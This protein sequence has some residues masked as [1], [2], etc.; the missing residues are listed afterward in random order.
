MSSILDDLENISKQ[1]REE[2]QI[3]NDR[4]K[5]SNKEEVTNKKKEEDKLIDKLLYEIYTLIEYYTKHN[6]CD[7]TEN[8]IEIELGVLLSDLT[9]G[10]NEC[11]KCRPTDASFIL[12]G[13]Y[14]FHTIDI[15]SRL[16]NT[17]KSL[18]IFRVETDSE[19]TQGFTGSKVYFFNTKSKLIITM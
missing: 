15:M 16:I 4:R 8:C 11:H 3:L 12:Y 2:R 9:I 13:G 6:E 1:W 5:V 17:L 19:G 14:K 10:P 18:N 7:R